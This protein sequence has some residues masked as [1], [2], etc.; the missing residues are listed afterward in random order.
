MTDK[1]LSELAAEIAKKQSCLPPWLFDCCG[2]LLED[3]REKL[4]GAAKLVY[5]QAIQKITGAKICD[6]I[7]C[8]SMAGYYYTE[9]DNLNLT[10]LLD[11]SANPYIQNTLTAHEN[12][13]FLSE[14]FSINYLNLYVG[15][16]LLKIGS[17]VKL[18]NSFGQYSVKNRKWINTPHQEPKII[19]NDEILHA[20]YKKMQTFYEEIDNLKTNKAKASVEDCQKLAEKYLFRTYAFIDFLDYQSYRL[21]KYSGKISEIRKIVTGI[22]TY[23]LTYKE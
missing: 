23:S 2:N 19:S 17:C 9:Q 15:E 10:L 6:V 3:I 20:A 21:L 14:D 5:E 4:M 18:Y 16:Q 12:F 7:L 11:L 13:L 22:Y 1:N 8:G